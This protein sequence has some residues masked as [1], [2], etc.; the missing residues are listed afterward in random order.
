VEKHNKIRRISETITAEKDRLTLFASRL[1]VRTS[2]QRA[3]SRNSKKRSGKNRKQQ[4]Q[5]PRNYI[6]ASATKTKRAG[7]G[8]LPLSDLESPLQSIRLL[9]DAHITDVEQLSL[10]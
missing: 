8:T 7:L 6:Y 5:L 2:T 1:G 4:Q 9:A 10:R 3:K